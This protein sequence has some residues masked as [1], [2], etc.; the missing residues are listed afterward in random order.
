MLIA[1]E[2]SGVLWNFAHF[3]GLPFYFKY[4]DKKTQTKQLWWVGQH[5]KGD[6]NCIW[7]KLLIYKL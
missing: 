7:I 6:G 5:S 3:N 2:M 1:F 4:K